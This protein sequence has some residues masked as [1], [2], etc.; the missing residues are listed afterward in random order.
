MAM[1][2]QAIGAGDR[3]V[4]QQSG[5]DVGP[6]PTAVLQRVQERH[7][8]DQMGRDAGE[9]EFALVQGLADQGE[10]ELLEVPKAAVEELAGAR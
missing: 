10:V 8:V 9:H 3:V 6:F 1:A 5:A 4:H 7:G 2:G